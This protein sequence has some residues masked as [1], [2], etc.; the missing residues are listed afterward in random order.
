MCA[1]VTAGCAV[2]LSFVMDPSVV[3]QECD[4]S[5][6]DE[7][8]AASVS[9]PAPPTTPSHKNKSG[10]V[11]H[12]TARKMA[13]HCYEFWRA[14]RP[15]RTVEET[16]ASVA[17]M[18]GISSRTVFQVRKEAQASGGKLSTPSKKRKRRAG[19]KQLNGSTTAASC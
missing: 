14:K 11:L 3:K 2:P 19:K 13:L 5:S 8:G 15:D 12:S 18:L 9:T 10:I 1:A 4:N 7:S 16:S 6:P 17:E